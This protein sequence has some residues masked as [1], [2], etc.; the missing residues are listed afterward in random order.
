MQKHS[1]KRRT[2]IL[3]VAKKAGV[4]K[5]TVSRYLGKQYDEL[6]ADT[7]KKIEAA[8]EALDY[9]PNRMAAG[10]KGG[11]SYLIGMVVADI[12][13]PFTTKILHAAETLCRN[14]G[15]SLMVCNTNNDPQVERDYIFMLQSHRIDGLIINTTGKNNQFL[16]QMAEQKTS[17]VLVDRKIPELGFD[18]IGV[19]NITATEEAVQFLISKNYESIAF[20]SEPIDGVSTRRERLSAFQSVLAMHGNSSMQHVYEADFSQTLDLEDKLD[21]FLK[22]TKG[23]K[24]AIFS[25]NGVVSLGLIKAMKKRGLVIPD[26]MAIIGFDDPDWAEIHTPALTTISQP[27]TAIG[28]TVIERVFKRIEGDTAPP[29]DIV[30]PAELLVRHSTI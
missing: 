12:T 16:T 18:S 25:A 17:V 14:K 9:K 29:K 8:I 20:F 4:S 1:N 23:K 13:N 6:A 19:D 22:S 7:R 11:R 24:R 15:Y 28:R 10:L 2:T 26:D 27:T 5:T 21:H 30:L 3:D